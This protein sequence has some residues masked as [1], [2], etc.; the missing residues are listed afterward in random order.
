MLDDTLQ[1]NR[2]LSHLLMQHSLRSLQSG[3]PIDFL[4]SENAFLELDS[5]LDIEKPIYL[6]YMSIRHKNFQGYRPLIY[7]ECLQYLH[8]AEYHT[9]GKFSS[10]LLQ[11]D[12]EDGLWFFQCRE[13]ADFGVSTPISFLRNMADDL[14]SD[15]EKAVHRKVLLL[16]YPEQIGCCQVHQ[17]FHRFQRTLK[18]MDFSSLFPSVVMC[19]HDTDEE[20]AH[21]NGDDTA[22][23]ESLLRESRYCLLR[24]NKQD[25]LAIL[26][27]LQEICQIGH[28]M[29]NLSCVRIYQAAALD[30]LN[31][32][33]SNQLQEELSTR[34]AIYPLYYTNNFTNW[35]QAFQYLQTCAGHVFRLIEARGASRNNST[36]EK[37]QKH[38]QSHIGEQ[39]NL[40]GIAAAVNY[41]ETYV[42]RLFRQHTGMKISDYILQERLSKAKQLLSSSDQNI[43]TIAECCGFDS[44]HYFS[45][46]FKKN[47]GMS[48]SDYRRQRL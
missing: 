24:G 35:I 45:Y 28:S 18:G 11:L 17:I 32:I 22:A 13:T 4:R 10:F 15:F 7:D 14:A 26:K 42:S 46:T 37:I 20:R 34:T 3:M 21:P 9:S 19:P 8:L 27:Q 38:I 12:N 41:N 39:L 6:M 29:H 25:Y 1:R 48:P 2:Y 47:V 36:I 5:P 40:A 30:L 44:I 16:L 43:N 31:Y 33:D 23:T